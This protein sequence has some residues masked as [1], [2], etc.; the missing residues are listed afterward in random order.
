MFLDRPGWR[1]ALAARVGWGGERR[2]ALPDGCVVEPDLAYGDDVAQRLDVYRPAA[3]RDA[4][5]LF[6]VH[7]GGWQRGDK[8][9]PRLIG[10]KVSHWVARGLVVVSANY[11]TLPEADPLTQ[12]DDVA[13]ALAF[14]QS[15]A[16][17]WGADPDRLVLMGHSAGAHLVSLVTADPAIGLRHGVRPWRGTVALDSGAFDVERIMTRRHFALYD[18]AFGADPAYWRE[19]SPV[20]RLREAMVA[21]MLI[22]S[23]TRRPDAFDQARGF[24]ERA[25]SLGGQVRVL[26]LDVSHGEA[27]ELVGCPGPYTEE[28]DAFMRAVGA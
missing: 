14:V 23:S 7:G 19:A 8:S 3:A 5:L 13:R 4:A 21:P 22:V 25:R 17:A 24:A 2:P 16:P 9:D 15:R 1:A 20:C 10:N 27:N 12:A 11:R 26:A 6:M 28:I 18:R